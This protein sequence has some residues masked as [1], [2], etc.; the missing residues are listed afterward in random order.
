MRI[1]QLKLLA[2]GAFTDHL[3]NLSGPGLH[4]VYGRNEAGK[5][6]AL[7]SLNQLLYGIDERSKYSFQHGSRMRIEAR[8]RSASGETLDI[9]RLKARKNPLLDGAGAPLTQ[10]DLAPFLMGITK[11]T[12]TAEFALN[13]EELRKG[14]NLLASG[15]VD[16]DEA[17][18][19]SNSG[20]QL[21]R[22][23]KTIGER[24]EQLY[25][26]T[27]KLPKINAHVTAWNE[28]NGRI[29]DASLRPEA[30]SIA[31]RDV[32]EAQAELNAVKAQLGAARAEHAK[33]SRL[34]HAL[35]AIFQR[36]RLLDSVAAVQAEGVI[37]PA[38]VVK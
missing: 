18:T 30:Y 11:E 31:E 24:Q 9:A 15:K 21:T 26:R 17:L 35:P 34:E 32:S 36:Q 28:T 20:L 23:L 29:R 6:T 25:K 10:E 27:G 7:S 19:A 1:D 12:F 5:S 38:D 8:L 3:L 16:L 4:L 2:Y 13:S 14:G 37:A 33:L 22:V